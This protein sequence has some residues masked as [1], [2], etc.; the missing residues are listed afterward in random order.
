MNVTRPARLKQIR[1][2]LHVHW[3]DG[4]ARL[5]NPPFD[6]LPL[7]VQK[8]ETESARGVLLAPFWPAQAWF[9]RLRGLASRMHVLDDSHALRRLR[10]P[11]MATRRG[12]DRTR[13]EWS[14]GIRAAVLGRT[15]YATNTG[16]G[17]EAARPLAE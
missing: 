13:T 9:A 4:R 8:I 14:A 11:G 6:F 17:E 10:K 2:Q 16:G 7:T 5:R 3:D 1:E 15:G 12:R